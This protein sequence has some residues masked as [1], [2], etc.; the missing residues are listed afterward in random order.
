MTAIQLSPIDEEYIAFLAGRR[1]VDA[2]II[3]ANYAAAKAR[4]GFASREYRRLAQTIYALFSPVYGEETE[5]SI[6]EAHR[7]HAALHLYRHISY[8]YFKMARYRDWAEYLTGQIGNRVPVVVDYGCGLGY[9][10]MEIAAI[11]PES[12][13][14]LVDIDSMV[15]DFAAYRFQH[16]G[17]NY[18][19]I[20]VTPHNPHPQL[21]DHSICIAAE[22]MEHLLQPLAAYQN[23]HDAMENGGILV[24]NFG[25]HGREFFHVSPRLGELRTAVLRDYRALDRKHAFVKER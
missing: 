18:A 3:R 21:P 9:V 13:V 5:A 23:I 11:C 1:D 12:M 19:T 8:S 24:G 17:L 7:F 14:Y 2:A 4:F 6:I 20:P 10:A 16:R 25:D 15:L 22:V